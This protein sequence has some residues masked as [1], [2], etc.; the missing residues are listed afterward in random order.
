MKYPNKPMKYRAAKVFAQLMLLAFAWEILFPLTA[1]ALTSGPRQPE[2]MQFTPA[3]TSGMV[4]MFTGDFTYNLPLFELPG[5]NGGYPF[6]LS[7][8]SG[9]GMD[10]EATWVGLGWSLNPGAITRQMRGLPDE[11]KG[12][13]VEVEQDMLEDWTVG[14]GVAGGFELFGADFKFLGGENSL[15]G[16]NLSLNLY[17]NRYRGF[18]YSIGGGATLLAG[19]APDNLSQNQIGLGLGLS[20]DSQSGIDLNPKLSLR[21]MAANRNRSFDL[22]LGYNS[23]RGLVSLGL[24]RMRSTYSSFLNMR[25]GSGSTHTLSFAADAFVPQVI[26]E[27]AGLNYQLSFKTGASV[28]GADPNLDINGFFSLQQLRNPKDVLPAY[29]YQQ[30]EAAEA[31]SLTDFN[32]EKDGTL[33]RAS[34]FLSI[35]QLTPDVYSVTGQGIGGSFRPWRNDVGIISDRKTTSFTNS[36]NSG[37]E[38]AAGKA[39]WDISLGTSIVRSGAWQTDNEIATSTNAYKYGFHGKNSVYDRDYEPWYFKFSG[40][41]TSDP[42]AYFDFAEGTQPVRFGLEGRQLADFRKAGHLLN[43]LQDE[44]GTVINTNPQTAYATHA[45][46]R[47]R[48]SVIAS[49]TNAQLGG[50]DEALNE[51]LVQVYSGGAAT[52]FAPNPDDL[53]ATTRNHPAH[54]FAGMSVHS[55]G[56]MRYVY[57]LPAY[58]NRHVEALFSVEGE[59]NACGPRIEIDRDGNRPNHKVA[60]TDRFLKRTA[61]PAYPHSYLLTTVLG[62]DYVDADAT[63]GP[64]DGDLGYWVRFKYLKVDTPYRWRAPFIDANYDQGQL[65]TKEDDRGNYL[66]GERDNYYLGSAETKTH[67]AEFH[68]STRKDNRGAKAELQN[69]SDATTSNENIQS[70]NSWKLDSISV[71]SKSERF[72]SDG[73]LNGAAVPISVVHFEYNYELCQNLPNNVHYNHLGSAHSESGKLTLKRVWF[74]GEESTRGA[75]HPYEFDYHAN[76]ASENPNYDP[77]AQDRWGNYRPY[78]DTCAAV[79]YPYVDQSVVRDSLDIYAAAWELK[80]ITLPTGGRMQIHYEADDYG[81]VQNR[82]AMEM[83]PITGALSAGSGQ[84]WFKNGSDAYDPDSSRLRRLYVDLGRDMNSQAEL[85]A[86]FA[87][88][89]KVYVKARMDL[90]KSD[91]NVEEFVTAYLS[92][93]GHGTECGSFPCRTA[94]VELAPCDWNEG[95]LRAYHPLAVAAWTHLR[96]NLPQLV[97]NTAAIG[98]GNP[99]SS[100]ASPATNKSAVQQKIASL[101]SIGPELLK[102]LAGYYKHARNQGWAQQMDTNESWIRLNTPQKMKVGGGSRVAKIELFD[103]Y[104]ATPNTKSYSTTVGAVYA[105]NTEENGAAISSGVAS[106]EPM[107]GGDE[108]PW[109]TWIRY[110][111]ST[112]LR[113]DVSLFFEGPTNES[114]MPAPV[115]GYRKVTVKSLATQMVIDNPALAFIPTTGA[116]IH[117]FYTAKDFPVVPEHTQISLERFNSIIPIPFVGMLQWND[118]TGSQGYS[119]TLNDMHGKPRKVSNFGQERDGQIAPRPISWVEYEYQCDT[120]FPG[121]EGA[122]KVLNNEVNALT[123]DVDSTD[124]SRSQTERR[125]LGVDLD[126]YTDLREYAALTGNVGLAANVD[127]TLV[128]VL[129]V[130]PSFNY[131]KSRTRTA[132]INKVVHRSG[133]LKGV[134]AWNEGSL[135]KT[136]HLAFDAQTGRPLLTRVTNNYD[137]PVYSYQYPAF[138]AYGRMGAAYRNLGL[139]FTCGTL[140]AETTAAAMA[141]ADS[142]HF[143]RGTACSLNAVDRAELFVP[144]DELLVAYNGPAPAQA[145]YVGEHAGDPL[146]FSATNI[147]SGSSANFRIVR[148]GRRNLLGVNASEITSLNDPTRWRDT[149]S[150]WRDFADPS[151]IVDSTWVVADTVYDTVVHPCVGYLVQQFNDFFAHPASSDSTQVMTPGPIPGTCTG[152]SSADMKVTSTTRVNFKC[153]AACN[154]EFVSTSGSGVPVAAIA[155]IGNPQLAADPN[156]G[157]SLPFTG[158]RF[159][160][161][162]A[163]NNGPYP[164]YLYGCTYLDSNAYVQIIPRITTNFQSTLVVTP[165]SSV[166]RTE[167]FMLDSVLSATATTF[168]D[169]WMQDWTG[170]RFAYGDAPSQLDRLDALHP[171]ASG[172]RGVWRPKDS[173]V[174]VAER[175]QSAELNTRKDGTLSGVP[176][177]NFQSLTFADCAPNWRKVSEITRYSPYSYEVEN[178]DVLAV[179]STALYGYNGKLPTA[180]C[181][182]A[183]Q[184]EIGYEG[185]EEY[186]AG[187]DL[188]LLQ[189]GTGN[190]DFP[191]DFTAD[192]RDLV[193]FTDAYAANRAR[194]SLDQALV[195]PVDSADILVQGRNHGLLFDPADNCGATRALVRVDSPS[196]IGAPA[197]KDAVLDRAPYFHRGANRDDYAGRIGY[198]RPTFLPP[199]Q[200]RNNSV[201]YTAT[202]AHTG[203]ISFSWTG[204]SRMPQH[205][206]RLQPGKAYALQLWVSRDDEDVPFY[207]SVSVMNPDD[208]LGVKV[209]FLD[210]DDNLLGDSDLFEP[211][212]RLVEGWQKIEGDFTPPNGTEHVIFVL[213]SGQV[214]G[215][216]TKA[217]LDDIRIQPRTSKMTCY[218]YDIGDYRL[219]AQLD[220]DNFALIYHYDE[221]GNLYL[222]QKETYQGLRTLQ[223]SR[224]FLAE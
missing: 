201:A 114:N 72:L 108:N 17:Y 87:G 148:S 93:A 19:F 161:Y 57:G 147:A 23:R 141:G 103:D 207:Q 172:E 152:C 189:I 16:A 20:L 29:G 90:K 117:E 146:F 1:Q 43:Q 35:P 46:R 164:V 116:E 21:R 102:L 91:A 137:D 192:P 171:F 48:N 2:A 7:Y 209:R 38:V 104:A 203:Q 105:Y 55:A 214:D 78:T 123:F 162:T 10:Q 216:S 94:Y 182:N 177:F 154:A 165:D 128:P 121:T 96:S 126:Y 82:T 81:Y 133:I 142:S 151:A 111:W 150:C 53:A 198:R 131:G 28:L 89:D 74:T 134:T 95:K 71:Y 26:T 213:Q 37:F 79:R 202:K 39:G 138:W 62:Q 218:V 6:N 212:G 180:V 12:D 200:I 210:Q 197:V 188:T 179:Y 118:L 196:A 187:A 30:L 58:N 33:R 65:S 98:Q 67:I 77:L 25:L 149:L 3:N 127:F 83:Y 143:F 49:V 129:T 113:S 15:F 221:G 61:L 166:L 97:A 222:T 24:Q 186:L 193:A 120:Q 223:E 170:V 158:L 205:R 175:R 52:T 181:A 75:L 56:G 22:G 139:E 184:Q 183:Q 80:E 174:Y 194:V 224:G 76:I 159:D 32:R 63:P 99:L 195:N 163:G 215:S 206:L 36:A 51:Y 92:V 125:L 66:Y 217:Y 132:V 145:V 54:H 153:S 8:R 135:I 157:Q 11:F 69:G 208:R 34:K 45:K 156:L 27:M 50:N 112:P 85:D 178:R 176:M 31:N 59:G 70:G 190:L 44:F 101:V 68:L 84:V 169:A 100:G 18:G 168:S 119:I 73:S 47:S 106:Y 140:V 167:M 130:W 5:P 40:E 124:W 173:Y 204:T 122:Y 155:S 219:R 42:R 86:V 109:R 13:V 136:E 144:G 211:S 160:L 107:V 41:S 115:V 220:D 9:I 64:S 60:N 4:D 199:W 88:L 185:F 14:V 191:T 110:P